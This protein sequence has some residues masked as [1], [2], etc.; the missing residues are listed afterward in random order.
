MHDRDSS[1]APARHLATRVAD[2][3][4]WLLGLCVVVTVALRAPGLTHHLFNPDE[5]Y[6]VTEARVMR[7]GGSLYHSVVDRKPPGMPLLT[8]A[9]MAVSGSRSVLAY[10]IPA[11]IATALTAWLIGREALRRFGRSAVLPAVALFLLATVS[12]A[13]L[14]PGQAAN[15]ETF[16]ILAIMAALVAA[17]RG[18]LWMAGIAIALGMLTRQTTV[19]LV[20]AVFIA[21][22]PERRWR[23]LVPLVVPTVVLTTVVAA[24]LGW[25]NYWFWNGGGASSDYLS[26]PQSAAY[27]VNNARSFLFPFIVGTAAIVALAIIGASEWRANLDL[28]AWAVGGAVASSLGFRFLDHYFI[29]MLPGMVL[30]GAAG[31]RFVTLRRARAAIVAL[32]VVPAFFGIYD[33]WSSLGNSSGAEDAVAYV[34]ANTTPKDRIFMWG[35]YAEMYTWTDRLP[36]TRFITSGFLTGNTPGRPA[37]QEG[38]KPV[39]GAWKAF[40]EDVAAHPPTLILDLAPTGYRGSAYYPISRYPELATLV[41]RDYVEVATEDGIVIY[42]HR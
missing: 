32:V 19:F 42:R 25:K 6:V 14:V 18:R 5:A 10:R 40:D 29:Q 38:V 35:A 17:V 34:R 20:P 24:S 39:P 36:A 22:W 15:E 33:G 9:A 13:D 21:A 11:M 8:Y 16:V 7:A 30:L 4:W 28:C 37:D 12:I 27:T 26:L 3:G 2:N 23:A 31:W 1:H 41:S